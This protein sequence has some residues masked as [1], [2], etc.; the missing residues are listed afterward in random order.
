VIIE[1]VHHFSLR[2]GESDGRA[3]SRARHGNGRD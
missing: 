1:A 2:E 3:I